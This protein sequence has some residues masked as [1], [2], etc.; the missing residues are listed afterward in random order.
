MGGF[1]GSSRLK[2][3][4]KYSP[5]T[6]QWSNVPDM[7]YERSNFAIEILDDMIFVIGGYNGAIKIPFN[8]CFSVA[9]NQWFVCFVVIEKTG[10]DFFY[11]SSK[12]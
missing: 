2:T 11:L 8:E 7:T 4:E 3:C 1:N 5:T 12:V 10:I 6:N 9:N